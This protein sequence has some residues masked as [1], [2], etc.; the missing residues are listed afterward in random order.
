MD[1]DQAQELKKQLEIEIMKAIR[2]YEETTGLRVTKA[3]MI[4]FEDTRF[5]TT[6]MFLPPKT[7]KDKD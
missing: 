2:G 6:T 5:F 1:I 4:N 7:R 3:E